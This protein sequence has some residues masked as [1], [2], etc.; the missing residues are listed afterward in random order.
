LAGP[1]VLEHGRLTAASDIFSFCVIFVGASDMEAA[2]GQGEN[3]CGERG[4]G[5]EPGKR[6]TMLCSLPCFVFG[7]AFLR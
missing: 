7:C 5:A 1:E 6:A 2:L 4:G 3:V